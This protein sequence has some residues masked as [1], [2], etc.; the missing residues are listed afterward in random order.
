MSSPLA[1][2]PVRRAAVR[3]SHVAVST[4]HNWEL[5]ED[6]PRKQI[7]ALL[8]TVHEALDL[9]K[10]WHGDE[11]SLRELRM[12]LQGYDHRWSSPKLEQIFDQALNDPSL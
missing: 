3:V 6:P 7:D 5:S 4:I 9:I 10:R 11:E 12:Y 8:K 1:P 2:E